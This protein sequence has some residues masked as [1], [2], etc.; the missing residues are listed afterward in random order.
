MEGQK[1]S[2]DTAGSTT[3]NPAWQEPLP[4]SGVSQHVPAAKGLLFLAGAEQP[5]RQ[6]PAFSFQLF[7]LDVSSR[8]SCPVQPARS[9]LPH[10][11]IRDFEGHPLPWSLPHSCRWHCCHTA[12]D[13]GSPHSKGAGLKASPWGP[14]EHQ[15]VR[16]PI[17]PTAT[18]PPQAP[19]L[20]KR[21]IPALPCS[22]HPSI[23]T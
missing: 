1:S 11:Q 2:R 21:D 10:I 8:G 5:R 18:H 14:E 16:T 15:Q 3:S 17:L 4:G 12:K 13:T 9:E 7:L 6:A 19:S 23:R 22:I 20:P